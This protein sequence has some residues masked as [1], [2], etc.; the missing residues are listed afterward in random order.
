[1][2]YENR[3]MP[4]PLPLELRTRAVNAYTN[5]E[6]TVHEIAERFCICARSLFRWLALE[7]SG[8]DLSPKHSPHGFAPKIPAD[9]YSVLGEL[10]CEKS[11]RTIAELAHVWRQKTG[12]IVSRSAMGRALLRAGLTLKKRHSEQSNEIG[13]M[14]VKKNRSSSMKLRISQLK[15]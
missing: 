8:N 9:K 10:C 1:M 15:S 4:K 3:Y 7:R 2:I 11:D 14:F 12:Q 6:G 5:G 13:K